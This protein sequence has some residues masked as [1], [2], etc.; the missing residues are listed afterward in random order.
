MIHKII[1][2]CLANR[3]VTLFSVVALLAL[4]VICFK[5]LPIDAYPDIDDTNFQVITQWP[6]HAAEEM[7]RLVTIPM[8]TAMNG[9]PHHTLVRSTSEFELSIVTID[10]DEAT[11][12]FT[13]M[14]YVQGKMST[15]NL[16]AGVNS[17]ISPLTSSCGQILFYTL[18][19]DDASPMDLKTW[20]DWEIQKRI[21][22]VP[23]VVDDS[24]LGGFTKQYQVNLNPL[25][26]A[27]YGLNI[28]T[29]L[30]AIN[31]NNQNTGGG[32]I[33]NG[34]QLY[35]IRAI[36]DAET[37]KNLS[38]IVVAEHNGTPVFLKNL[39]DVQ[40]GHRQLLGD[41]TIDFK[42]PDGSIHE[43]P[44]ALV[45]IAAGLK[46]ADFGP[47]LDGLHDKI[48]EINDTV[49]P[50]DIRLVPVIDRG[51]LLRLVTHTV[52][53]NLSVGM[54]L[55]LLILLF[56]L[57]NIR[58]ALIVAC[59]IPFSLLFASI[60][61]DLRHIPANLLSLG[62]LDFGMVVDG[63]VVMVENIFRYKEMEKKSGKV[64]DR[65][66]LILD[67]ASEV[68]RPIVFAIAI[69]ILAYLPIFT[70][71]RVEGRLF[72]PMAWTVAFALLGAMVFVVT[73]VPV[74]CYYVLSGKLSEWHNPVLAWA[75]NA[76]Q[77][78]LAWCLEHKGRIVGLSL[79][80]F[81]VAVWLAVR[82][83]GSEF[84]PHLDEGDIWVRGTLPN[85]I[86]YDAAIKVADRAR[87][88]LASYPE[89]GTVYSQIGRPD[90][91][92]DDGGYY[93][94]EY[95]VDLKPKDEWRPQF[96]RK[97]EAL[98]AAMN[99]DLANIP[100]VD[101]NFSQAIEDN[102]SEALTGTHGDMDVELFGTDLQT[103]DKLATQIATV[104]QKVPG[105]VDVGVFRELAQPNINILVNR[106]K[107]ARYGLNVSDVQTV[108]QTAVG[109]SV[110]CQVV[111]GEKLFDI[112]VRYQP[113]YRSTLEQIKK[114][115]VATPDGYRIPLEAL[116]DFQVKEGAAIVF[117][118]QTRRFIPIKFNVRGSDL[119]GTVAAAQAAVAK[120][121][122]LPPGYSM[123]WAGEFESESRANKRLSIIIPLTVVAIFL[124]LYM[125]FS[126][127]KWAGVVMTNLMMA[128]IGG[129]SAL[130]ITGTYFSVSSGIGFL[131]LF[132]VSVQT[133]VLLV[134]YIH[135]MRLKG[136]PLRQSILEGSRL[137]LRPIM[138]T[139]LV[140]TFGLI[141]AAMSH[142][143][144]SDSQRPMAIVIVGGLITDLIMSFYLLPIF[145]EW[146]AKD[147][148][149]LKF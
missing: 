91:G 51:K 90:D 127:V 60:L 56:L 46:G 65:V 88:I 126:S 14:Q 21:L 71:Q 26:L 55:V 96:K 64:S 121:I 37:V 100:G 6:G 50:K 34:E 49:L 84:L 99:K 119:G 40:V 35:N 141:P 20:H 102:V 43:Q 4:G 82:V 86:S 19:S 114:I 129:V 128:V 83:I 123:N 44:H 7:E 62:A 134:S 147:N 61:L 68:E 98:I 101:W 107:I 47:I 17:G 94:S 112:M 39:G 67:A 52:E 25:A 33:T 15:A 124:V 136:M 5:A 109:G 38:S 59:T 92:I 132:G 130:F 103:L 95:F 115:T 53:E 143:I 32:F 120:N 113:Q 81:G 79:F 58:S 110:P 3:L 105:M 2:F 36:G 74:I 54:V 72:S 41:L 89:T 139:A 12:P 31:N 13:A 146:F 85:S 116:C 133:G 149:E 106:D 69:I 23:G 75:E 57:G 138:M 125:V 104:M 28:P 97:K 22:S 131:A 111:E 70:L 11:D 122:L 27:N 142:E 135:Q 10:F 77:K 1:A 66:N 8:E 117:R 73:A 108:I 140:A 80:A 29:V 118:K 78:S 93:D 148:E 76:Y 137:R 9:I 144:G 63:T 45:S 16:P 24:S 18:K 87:K 42:N 48:K 30:N 145:Y